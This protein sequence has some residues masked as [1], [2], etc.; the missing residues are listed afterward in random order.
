MEISKKLKLLRNEKKITQ[1]ILAKNINVALG[2]I[3]DI[4]SNR[5][6]PSK[7]TAMKLAQYSN[8]TVDYWIN[9]NETEMYIKNR[10]NFSSTARVI[11][12]LKE[13][14]HI[15]NGVPTEL[16]WQLLKEGMA[17]DLKFMELDKIEK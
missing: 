12:E 13:K 10:S 11:K 7:V 1:K 9:E 2:V 17:I 6:V 8:T 14:G 15:E 16:G 3:G 4:E 5:R